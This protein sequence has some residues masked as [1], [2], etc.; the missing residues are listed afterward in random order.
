LLAG[1]DTLAR[2][3]CVAQE[4]SLPACRLAEQ[5]VLEG[6]KKNERVLMSGTERKERNIAFT[7]TSKTTLCCIKTCNK[8]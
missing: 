4:I 6:R 3:L 1:G 5:W 8:F 2:Y 7:Y